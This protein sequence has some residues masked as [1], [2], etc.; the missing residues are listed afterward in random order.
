MMMKRQ[1]VMLN[2]MMLHPLMR[3]LGLLMQVMRS[4]A[5]LMPWRYCKTPLW[6]MPWRYPG[7]LWHPP[8]VGAAG[9]DH[10]DRDRAEAEAGL[11]MMRVATILRGAALGAGLG[12]GLH[13]LAEALGEGATRVS[14]LQK[15]KINPYFPY[16][17]LVKLIESPI[18]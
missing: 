12:A 3:S 17:L 10:R 13:L 2:Q 6:L 9:V 5:L 11:S 8:E 15:R 7:P 14:K 4:P 18:Y 16:F 1:K